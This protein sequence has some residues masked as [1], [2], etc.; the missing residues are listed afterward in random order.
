[1]YQN[2]VLLFT[3]ILHA[4]TT[5]TNESNV[6]YISKEDFPAYQAYNEGVALHREG[7]TSDA[8]RVYHVG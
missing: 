5:A 3:I 2:I 4:S 1:M 8:I 6:K 7:K